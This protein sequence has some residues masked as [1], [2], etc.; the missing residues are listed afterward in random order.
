MH[1]ARSI[2]RKLGHLIENEKVEQY[3]NEEGENMVDL[4]AI[5]R[6]SKAQDNK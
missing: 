6:A 5:E 2:K 3:I 1:A 4:V